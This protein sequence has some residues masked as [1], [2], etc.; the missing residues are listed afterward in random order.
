[1]QARKADQG[2]IVGKNFVVHTSK[3]NL[4]RNLSRKIAR[5]YRALMLGLKPGS[6]P[7][8][9]NRLCH[10]LNAC[11]L[12]SNNNPQ[13]TKGDRHETL[14]HQSIRGVAARHYI[15]Q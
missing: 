3:Q 12:K 1:M 5:L 10:A 13:I 6:P 14:S 7:A 15:A 11:A 9:T 4:S 8:H 2:K